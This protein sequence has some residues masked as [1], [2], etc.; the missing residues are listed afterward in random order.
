MDEWPLIDPTTWYEIIR[1]I[2]AQ[3]SDRWAMFIFT[4]KGRNHAYQM[5]VKSREA[6]EW[7]RY[8][9]N[10]E[11]SGII[12]QSELEAI[13]K[14]IPA[15]AYSQEFLCEF[16]DDSTSVFKGVDFCISGGLE[17]YRR[18]YS[19]VTGVDLAKMEDYTVLITICRETRHVVSYRRCTD[20]EWTV[21]K[22]MIIDEINKY[23][24]MAVIDATGVGDPIFED[25][26]RVGVNARPFKFNNTNKKEIIDRLS[27]CIEQ[28]LITFPEIV[29]L[30]DELKTYAYELTPSRN[31]RYN[32][33]NG[34]HDDSV[35]SLA[36][37]VWGMRNFIYNPKTL[38][39]K[40]RA[41][42]VRRVKRSPANAGIG[43]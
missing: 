26:K 5:W 29:P 13:K 19:Y 41:R 4:P 21:Q 42:A 30:I 9:L 18:E 23:R 6:K 12:P 33:P 17:P 15:M 1:P 43:F 27:V 39:E 3:S 11:T 34:M 37:A 40:Q 38:E 14:E 20:V 2:V 7:G 8:T 16:G 36:L 31:V 22:E 28:R 32:A 35:I 10:A 25:L 24:S